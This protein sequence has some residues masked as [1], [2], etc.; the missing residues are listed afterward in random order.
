MDTLY[1]LDRALIEI[2]G[3]DARTFLQDLLTQDLDRLDAKGMEYAAL[4]S[5]QGKVI[6]DML[7]WA[8]GKDVLIDVDSKYAAQVEKR[9]QMYKLRRAVTIYWTEEIGPVV[10][11]PEPFEGARRDPRLEGLGWRGFANVRTNPLDGAETFEA[12]RIALGVP[13]LARDA[14][15]EEVFA[16]EALLEEL[17]GVA[18]DKGCFVG[19]ENVSRMKR[20]ATTRKKFCPVVFESEPIAYG[21]PVLA[22]AAEIGSVRSGV[23]GRAIALLRLDRAL[24]AVAAG[25][26]LT[27]AG[28]QIRL[29]PPPWLILPQ[30]EGAP[31]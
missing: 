3:A 19:Q 16:G 11:S 24:E 30:R 28:R 18:F 26:D 23:A 8:A 9:L 22:G 15:P 1:R 6:A 12:H 21:A 14:Q 29:D 17:N 25:Q 2:S 7:L 20:R 13:D 10:W 4:L 5:P 31:H 27:A